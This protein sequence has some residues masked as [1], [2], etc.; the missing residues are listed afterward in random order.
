MWCV[1]FRYEN[2][3]D[4][5]KKAFL[6]DCVARNKALKAK[7]ESGQTVSQSERDEIRLAVLGM[8]PYNTDKYSLWTQHRHPNYFGEWCAWLSFA[9]AA[10]PSIQ[11]VCAESQV[12]TFG[13][14]ACCFFGVR[15]F[16]DCLIH[17]TGAGPAEHFSSLKRDKYKEY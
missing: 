1:A 13:M 7:E 4:L 3:A 6:A 8:P 9:I 16:Y 14:L 15:L 2:R 5:Q 11:A 12:V 10:V 17:W